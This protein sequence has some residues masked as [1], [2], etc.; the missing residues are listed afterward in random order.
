MAVPGAARR[1]LCCGM[2]RPGLLASISTEKCRHTTRAVA[3]QLHAG[4]ADHDIRVLAVGLARIEDE[5]AAAGHACDR[6]VDRC[7]VVR[8]TVPLRSEVPDVHDRGRHRRDSCLRSPRSQRTSRW[9]SVET[10][11]G[12]SAASATGEPT[13]R[14]SRRAR[15]SYLSSPSARANRA[16]LSQPVLWQAQATSNATSAKASRFIVWRPTSRP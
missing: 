6:F 11:P 12:A 8:N 9:L 5:G 16:V 4:L 15:A 14:E 1:T 10:L 13:C 2:P 7:G 3:P